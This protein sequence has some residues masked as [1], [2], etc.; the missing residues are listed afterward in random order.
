MLC[1]KIGFN[2]AEGVALR[3]ARLALNIVGDNLIML[4]PPPVHLQVVSAFSAVQ[5]IWYGCSIERG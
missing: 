2:F 1:F 4:S 5:Y 3:N